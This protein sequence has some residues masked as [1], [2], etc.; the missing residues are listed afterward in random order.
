MSQGNDTA[1]R[2]VPE[3]GGTGLD[4]VACFEGGE[5]IVFLME[6]KEIVF[7]VEETVGRAGRCGL[8]PMLG[9]V[10][11]GVGELTDIGELF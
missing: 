6:G 7:L 4:E 9:V 2:I 1:V 3:P 8:L 10:A 11:V 5:E